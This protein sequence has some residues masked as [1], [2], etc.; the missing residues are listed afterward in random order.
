MNGFFRKWE[1]VEPYNESS[2]INWQLECTISSGDVATACYAEDECC[3]PCHSI[4]AHLH[5]EI[6]ALR[7]ETSFSWHDSF[8]LIIFSLVKW[9][10]LLIKTNYK[11]P[12][13]SSR[14][15]ILLA[16]FYLWHVCPPFDR[17]N[18]KFL[19][20]LCCLKLILYCYFGKNWYFVWYLLQTKTPSYCFLL[21]FFLSYCETLCFK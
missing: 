10:Y 19:C 14:A 11:L 20:W 7:I 1:V 21:S 17:P 6:D 12:V 15:V 13:F 5:Q 3:C 16:S 9:R 8:S 18:L 2:T 4:S